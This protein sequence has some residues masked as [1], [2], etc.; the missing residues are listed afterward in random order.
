MLNNDDFILSIWS[1]GNLVFMNGIRVNQCHKVRNEWI[2]R[3]IIEPVEIQVKII[4]QIYSLSND[5]RR[6]YV[7]M[8]VI[9]D[10]IY[11]NS[12]LCLLYL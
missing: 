1:V 8:Q 6:Y 7:V 12:V 9:F 2:Q 3:I 4:R 5:K 10:N 11:N